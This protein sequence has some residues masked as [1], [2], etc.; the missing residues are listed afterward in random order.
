MDRLRCIEVFLAVARAGTFT[1]AAQHL[2]ISKAN[3]TRHIASLEELFGA[4]LINRTTTQVRLTDAGEAAFAGAELLMERYEELEAAS[5]TRTR[6]L[7][8]VIHI[9]TPPAFGA[10]HLTRAMA[11]FVERYPEVEFSVSIDLGFENLIAQ[12]LDVSVRIGP[13]P[14]DASYIA[15][16]LTAAPQ[17]LVASRS[18]L[19][20]KGV[21]ESPAELTAHNCLLHLIK[22]PTHS[23]CFKDG[24]VE[25]SVQV[26][27]SI[28][29]N[30]GDVLK[31]AA[32]MG[33][34]ISMHPYYM[35]S[36]EL[37]SGTLIPVLLHY[38]PP[39]LNIYVVYPTR[40]NLPLRV[41]TFVT[42]L[43]DWAQVPLPGLP[44]SGSTPVR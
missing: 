31:A 13:P 27:G 2:R 5:R 23:W 15:I 38:Q 21:P 28:R 25:T 34:G 26:S 8:G 7:K 30:L 1:A 36:D 14:Q 42:H 12:G 18:Y 32:L 20:R 35:V 22:A 19:S 37:S 41:K 11:Q 6:G 39:S 29:S 3:V 44:H 24:D 16:P 40:Q 10:A 33:H 17:V 9:G 4:R 43:R